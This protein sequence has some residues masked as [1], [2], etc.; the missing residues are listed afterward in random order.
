MQTILGANG[1][2]GRELAIS[3]KREFTDNIRLVSR[4]PRKINDSDQLFKADLL[5][6]EQ[7][8]RAVEG[9]EIVYLTAG[10][11]INT[12]QWVEQWPIIMRNVIDA[13]STHQVKLVY[14]DNTYM[15]PQNSTPLTEESPFAPVGAKGRVRA[16]ITRQLLEAMQAGRI[17]ALICRA[18]EFYGPGQT[19]SITNSVVLEPLLK[20]DKARVFLRDDTLRSLIYTPDASRAMALL[21]NTPDAYNQTWHLPCD[22]N[23]LTY[24]EFIRLA[25]DIFATT[26]DY[27]VMEAWKLKFA[28]LINRKVRE[29]EELLPRYKADNI[30]VSDKFKRR[31]PDFVVTPYQRGLQA[32]RD[33]YLNQ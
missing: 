6:A 32:M 16:A 14:F 4:N 19:Q 1:Q 7:T 18:P 20:G 28:A 29:T 22:D 10:L 8:L 24:K 33:G 23:R 5:D 2:I 26:A 9:S 15:Y 17:K 13:C 3:L 30:F 31:F 21:G 11:P 12:A 25:A 27:Q